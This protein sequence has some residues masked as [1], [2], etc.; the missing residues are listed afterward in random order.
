MRF[1]NRRAKEKRLKKDNKRQWQN[2]AHTDGKIQR[3]KKRTKNDR[4]QSLHEED[5]TSTEVETAV[6]YDGTNTCVIFSKIHFY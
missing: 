2:T 3:K 4:D 1:Q 5:A 6:S